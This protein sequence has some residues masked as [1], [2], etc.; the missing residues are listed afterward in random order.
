[1]KLNDWIVTANGVPVLCPTV[2]KAVFAEPA[3]V[4]ANV[5]LSSIVIVGAVPIGP[6]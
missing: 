5:E 6:P 2:N 3:R 1:M 4:S